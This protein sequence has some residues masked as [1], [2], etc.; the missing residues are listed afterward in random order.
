MNKMLV[1][2]AAILV[3]GVVMR[4]QK[5][6]DAP[7]K[8]MSVCGAPPE[9]PC[10]EP[11]KALKISPPE[12]SKEAKAAKIEGIVLLKVL[13]GLNGRAMDI[14]VVKGPGYGL[15]GQAAKTVMKKWVFQPATYNGAPVV[16]WQQV[17]VS[18]HL[19]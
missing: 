8:Y 19:F 10:A 12:Y 4:A 6:S 15:E 3:M 11:A 7:D 9:Q 17:Q 16:A 18:F 1:T 13:V 5:P 14:I 2:T